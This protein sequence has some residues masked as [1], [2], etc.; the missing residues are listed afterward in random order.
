MDYWSQAEAKKDRIRS[1]DSASG[2]NPTKLGGTKLSWEWICSTVTVLG[3]TC[4]KNYMQP[5]LAQ[6]R[7]YSGIRGNL[8]IYS[9]QGI[10]DIINSIRKSLFLNNYYLDLC[11]TNKIST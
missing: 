9:R 4:F 6:D 8:R 5:S 11:S 1:Q 7:W 3:K 10:T 2:A